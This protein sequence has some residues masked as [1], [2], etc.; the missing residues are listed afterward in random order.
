MNQ[1]MKN[2]RDELKALCAPYKVLIKN[3]VYASMND[4]LCNY[5]SHLGHTILKSYRR[6]REEGY[7]VKWG[8]KALLMWGEPKRQKKENEQTKK[9]EETGEKFYPVA[10]VFSNLQVEKV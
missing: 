4:A 9:E 6:W 3:G 5:Y 10:Y 7:Q 8:S 2:K 1:E